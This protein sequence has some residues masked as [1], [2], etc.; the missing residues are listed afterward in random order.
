M[1]KLGNWAGERYGPEFMAWAQGPLVQASEAHKNKVF[2]ESK[3]LHEVMK[4]GFELYQEFASG[5]VE[6]GYG[7][8]KDGSYSE[9]MSNESA[10]H[11][12][13]EL[14]ELAKDVRAFVE[15]PLAVNQRRLERETLKD[16]HFHKLFMMVQDDLNIHTWGQFETRTKQLMKRVGTELKNCPY[17]QKFMGLLMRMK[18]L[19]EKERQ[20]SDLGTPEPPRTPSTSCKSSPSPRRASQEAGSGF[21]CSSPRWRCP[22]CRKS[23]ADHVDGGGRRR[24]G[25]GG[26]AGCGGGRRRASSARSP[27]AAEAAGG[28]GRGRSPGT[29]AAAAAPSPS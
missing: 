10:R 28:T 13:E 6:M 7:F 17:F 4:D 26:P 22:S 21:E 24:G 9:W 14:Y 15:S 23:D 8:E 1:E 16:P 29:D 25:V 27:S 11:V 19:C 18:A 12:F 20:V 2:H 5:K 3:E